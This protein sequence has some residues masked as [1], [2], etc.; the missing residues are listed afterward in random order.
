MKVLIISPLF[1]PQGSGAEI[2]S[3]LEAK[4]LAENGLEVLLVT[5]NYVKL[6]ITDEFI[7]RIKIYQV[8]MFFTSFIYPR[9]IP[10]GEFAYWIFQENS[11]KNISEIA[12]KESV[13]LIHIEHAYIGFSKDNSALPIILT[14]RDYWPIC[15]YRVLMDERAVCCANRNFIGGFRCRWE[16]Y[17]EYGTAK[18]PHLLYNIIFTPLLHSMYKRYN[19]MIER[20]LK[21]VDQIVTISNFLKKIIESGISLRSKEIQVIYPSIGNNAYIPRRNSNKITFTYI[22]SLEA[23]KG[24]IKLVNSFSSIVRKNDKLELLICGEG[25][26]KSRIREYI[27]RNNLNKHIKLLG[28]IDH[29]LIGKVYENTDVVV[30]PSLWPEPYGRVVIESLVAG[31]LVIVNPVGA[32]KEQVDDGINGFYANCYDI[33]KLAEKMLEITCYS[34]DEI[35]SMGIKAREYTLKK[36]NP[37]ERIKKLIKIYER[38]I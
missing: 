18:F 32:L 6:D 26:L 10:F 28:K 34:K 15:P 11:W 16:I 3:M 9:S 8:P 7:K 37:K 19:I 20:K 35:I 5:N 31:R 22:G 4:E 33:K 1:P 27:L 30:V 13:D 25:G 24:V 21:E 14:I 23:H 38:L 29:R 2:S 17:S 12:R 36:F